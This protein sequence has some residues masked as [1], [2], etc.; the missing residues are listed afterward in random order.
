[1]EAAMIDALLLV[2]ILGVTALA[3]GVDL[4]VLIGW[5]R[6]RWR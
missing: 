3:V 6:R 2:L 1:M 5:L 4:G